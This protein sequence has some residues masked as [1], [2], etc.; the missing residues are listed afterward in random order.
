MKLLIEFEFES[1]SEQVYNYNNW[2]LN[3]TRLTLSTNK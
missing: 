3:L 2:M 1:E